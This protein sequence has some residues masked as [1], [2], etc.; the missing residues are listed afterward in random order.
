MNETEPCFWAMISLLA[1]ILNNNKHRLY[2]MQHN[3]RLKP[4]SFAI[5]CS[6]LQQCQWQNE[7]IAGFHLSGECLFTKVLLVQVSHDQ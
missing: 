5:M 2:Q 7:F 1:A 3:P 4:V 6:L